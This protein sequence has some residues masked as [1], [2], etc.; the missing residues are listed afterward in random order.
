MKSIYFHCPN[1][2]TTITYHG[3]MPKEMICIECKTEFTAQE[4]FKKYEEES[5]EEN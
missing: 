1:C 3:I 2:N 4:L 5:D